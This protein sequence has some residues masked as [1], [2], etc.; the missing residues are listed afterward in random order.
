MPLV[1]VQNLRTWFP[2]FGGVFRHKTGEI[3][4]V[5]DV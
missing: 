3:K 2:V 1:S 5:D 4:A